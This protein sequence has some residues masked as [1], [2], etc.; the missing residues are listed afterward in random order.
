[1]MKGPSLCLGYV[2]KFFRGELITVS[3]EFDEAF[4]LGTM[5]YER[6][7]QRLKSLF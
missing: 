2:K 5:V 1:M 3:W 6:L 7:I 4:F